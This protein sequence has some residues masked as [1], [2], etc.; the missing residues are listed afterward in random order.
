MKLLN[1]TISYL[2]A[3]LF[4][5]V[6]GWAALLY[7]NLLDE[8]Y[9]SL[10]DGL[11][12]YKILIME[13]VEQDSTVLQR[14]SF[15]EFNY[16]IKPVSGAKVFSHTDVYTDTLMFMENEQDMEPVRMLKTVFE[17][18][19]SYYELRVINTMVETDD[20]IADLM[21]SIFWLY[22][23]L[24]AVILVLNNFLL[25]K[26][27]EPF[28]KLVHQLR[29]FKL[30]KQEQ[31]TFEETTVDEFRE[32]NQAV[33]KLIQNSTD[34]YLSQK[35]FIENASHEL[36]TPLA[37]SL[38]KLEL[39]VEENNLTEEQLRLLSG[40]IN[41][42]ERMARLNKSLLLLSKIENRQFIAEE[43]V[44]INKLT[45]TLLDDFE[46]Q[47]A[48][49]EVSITLHE[50]EE[51]R[52]QMNPDL[53]TVLLTNL[54]KNA[55]VHNHHNG[56]VT[57]SIKAHQLTIENTGDKNALDENRMFS[58]FNKSIKNDGSTGLGLPIVKAIADLY[59]FRVQYAFD[60]VHKLT[61]YFQVPAR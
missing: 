54:I 55:I 46:A 32:L 13:R 8:I 9:D 15:G 21:Y 31:V 36:Q 35:H 30:E 58:R 61:V 56:A 43:E 2:A 7:Y 49:K 12:N 28:Y 37:I 50:E 18:N 11:E 34:T 19:G 26:T 44:S 17:H 57:V 52:L 45:K 40:A 60:E 14:H 53:A 39:L 20:L 6:T 51:C 10:D 41:N 5:V 48:Y 29:K 16:A 38:N 27:W 22:L 42:L 25:K 24:L 3:I 1:H 4:V 47:A 59:N 33:A 23:G